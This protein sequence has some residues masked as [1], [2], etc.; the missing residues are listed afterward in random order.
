MSGGLSTIM[1]MGKCAVVCAG[2]TSLLCCAVVLT[3]IIYLAIFAFSNP[4]KEAW[5]GIVSSTT[6]GTTTTT[7]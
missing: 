6:A 5:Y 2:T 3:F 4:D 1:A 7:A